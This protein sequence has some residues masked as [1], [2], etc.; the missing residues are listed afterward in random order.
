MY[1]RRRSVSPAFLHTAMWVLNFSRIIQ[2]LEVSQT[3]VWILVSSFMSCVTVSEF[4]SLIE[5]EFLDFWYCLP[6]S[7]LGDGQKSCRKKNLFNASLTIPR[8]LGKYW[9][10]SKEHFWGTLSSWVWLGWKV[11]RGLVGRKQA[12]SMCQTWVS[13]LNAALSKM[14]RLSEGKSEPL[15]V[16]RRKSGR[17]CWKINIYEEKIQAWDH[18]LYDSTIIGDQ[19]GSNKI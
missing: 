17:I 2:L 10:E 18:L 3:C 15:K 12:F 1:F 13:T 8:Q 5:P 14:C 9:H 16:P 7:S 4:Y 11:D 19:W 6:N